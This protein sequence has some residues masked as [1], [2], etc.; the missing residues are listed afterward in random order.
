MERI[1]VAYICCFSTVEVRNN[2]KLSSLRV[3]NFFRRLWRIPVV[4]YE[5]KGIW[6]A[7]LVK[8]FENNSQYECYVISHHYGLLSHKQCFQMEGVNY[9]ILD[10]RETLLKKMFKNVFNRFKKNDYKGDGKRISKI[11]E[12][13][14]PDIVVVCGAENAIYSSSVLYI[15]K[16]PI[17]LILQTFANSAK[18]ISLGIGDDSWRSF[19]KDV[20]CHAK[21]FGTTNEEAIDYIRNNIPNAFCLKRIF[22][23]SIVETRRIQ[24]KE[25]DFVFYANGLSYYKGT[26]DAIKAFG[27]VCSKYP[28][29]SM[30]VIGTCSDDYKRHLNNISE[31]LKISNNITYYTHFP[32]QSDV[33]NQVCTAR[34]AVLPAITEP[35][36]TT[37]RESM[38]MGLP[39]IVY[40]TSETAVINYECMCLLAAEKEDFD[41]LGGK[42][43]YAYE[44]PDEMTEMAQRAKDYAMKRY[45]T[46]AAIKLMDK[47]IKAI[48][49]HYYKNE[50]IPRELQSEN[51]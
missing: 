33:L 2:I 19:E 8:T 51:L 34:Y 45:S 10:I 11:V 43:L 48:I 31:E 49:N 12:G 3:S 36:T 32:L 24:K 38:L 26:E 23:S 13:I 39:T 1:R 7:E 47:N 50:A 21:Y 28:H 4:R 44:H 9:I 46:D 22:P 25:F 18:R 27:Y 14:N 29:A 30:E 41:D 37:I 42:M 40:A 16:K 35:L 6:N 15:N 20:L 5:D 17:Y